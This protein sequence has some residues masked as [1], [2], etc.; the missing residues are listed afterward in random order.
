MIGDTLSIVYHA[1]NVERVV[2]LSKNMRI[3]LSSRNL[4][5]ESEAG[6]L[7]SAS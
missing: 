7:G 2:N 3:T 4:S 5:Q 1:I 6:C